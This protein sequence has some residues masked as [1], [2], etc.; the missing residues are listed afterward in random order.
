M[1][2]CLPPQKNKSPRKQTAVK[3]FIRPIPWTIVVPEREKSNCEMCAF[4]VILPPISSSGTVLV[5]SL[6]PY[7]AGKTLRYA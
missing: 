7:I 5:H 4:L 1:C 2:V 3:I 6:Y